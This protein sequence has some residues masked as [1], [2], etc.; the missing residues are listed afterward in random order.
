MGPKQSLHFL[1][2]VF[3]I[4]GPPRYA[5]FGH[6]RLK[7]LLGAKLNI[8][9]FFPSFSSPQIIKF[10]SLE[11]FRG[12]TSMFFCS[13]CILGPHKYADVVIGDYQM[14]IWG[15]NNIFAFFGPKNMQIL[16]I[17][18]PQ[19]TFG[20]PKS[21][22]FFSSFWP[23]KYANIG[24]LETPKWLLGKKKFLK[25]LASLA[26][27]ICKFWSLAKSLSRAFEAKQILVMGDP[28]MTWGAKWQ[29]SALHTVRY[30]QSSKKKETKTFY[31]T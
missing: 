15:K 9:I 3:R 10:A 26:P 11:T 1:S 28:H 18:E 20:P 25:F 19:M 31:C 6:W 24:L 30:K 7:W 13:I 27:K 14:T 22:W 8:C 23:P 21:L 17:E 4:F 16:V 5:S 12:K 2:S 29:S